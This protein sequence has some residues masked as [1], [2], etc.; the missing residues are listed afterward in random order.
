MAAFGVTSAPS[1]WF[2]KARY[3]HAEPVPGCITHHVGR[4]MVRRMWVGSMREPS[5]ESPMKTNSGRMRR[6]SS[7]NVG[8]YGRRWRKVSSAG[9]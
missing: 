9:R 7:R 3:H 5:I 4:L 6:M 8:S 2:L 1:T